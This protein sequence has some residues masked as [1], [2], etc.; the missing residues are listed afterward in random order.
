M[1]HDAIRFAM[2]F[3]LQQLATSEDRSQDPGFGPE[4]EDAGSHCVPLAAAA[5]VAI[6]ELAPQG[7]RADPRE[8][9]RGAGEGPGPPRVPGALGPRLRGRRVV[10]APGRGRGGGGGAFEAGRGGRGPG[11]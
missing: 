7:K 1:L 3:F 5:L 10:P 8:L 4:K 11:S 6:W 2:C 9:P